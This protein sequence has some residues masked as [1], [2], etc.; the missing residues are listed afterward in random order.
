MQ[1]T[2]QKSSVPKKKTHSNIFGSE[3]KGKAHIWSKGKRGGSLPLL[4][5]RGLGRIKRHAKHISDGGLRGRGV[6]G[7]A[8]NGRSTANY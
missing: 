2:L 5:E 7:S 3:R 6:G 4:E 1:I 8:S